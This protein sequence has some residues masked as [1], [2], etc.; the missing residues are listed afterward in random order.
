[1]DRRDLRCVGPMHLAR[2][3]EEARAQVRFGLE[4]WQ[5][6][7]FA[8]NPVA[9]GRPQPDADPVDAMIESGVA[10]IGTPDDAIEQISRLQKQT[11]GFGTFLFMAHNWATFDQTLQSYELFALIRHPA[12]RRRQ[13][14][15]DAYARRRGGRRCRGQAR[16]VPC[17]QMQI[18]AAPCLTSRALPPAPATARRWAD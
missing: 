17:V 13:G 7:F 16:L 4:K 5:R 11:G 10:V 15:D 18:P 9:G 1:M 8:L 6:Y 14:A 2:T 3:R 12:R